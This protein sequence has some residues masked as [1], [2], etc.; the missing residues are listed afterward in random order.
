MG[1]GDGTI[2]K[3]RQILGG[4]EADLPELDTGG[5]ARLSLTAGG[6]WSEGV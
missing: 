5:L 1:G 6:R 2:A 4:F 3:I